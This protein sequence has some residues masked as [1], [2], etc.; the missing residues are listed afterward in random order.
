MTKSSET[1]HLAALTADW[2]S[3][4]RGALHQ[5]A[6]ELSS[7]Q[8]GCIITLARKATCLV[9]ILIRSGLL[10]ARVPVVSDRILDMNATWLSGMEVVVVDDVIISGSSLYKLQQR[11]RKLGGYPKLLALAVDTQWWNQELCR[12]KQPYLKLDHEQIIALSHRIVNLISTWPRPYNIDWPLFTAT[13]GR[14]SNEALISMS[15]WTYGSVTTH[16]QR[17]HDVSSLTFQPGDRVVGQL[18]ESIGANI[19]KFT[20]MKKVRVVT[21]QTARGLLARVCPIVI[22]DIVREQD[23]RSMFDICLENTSDDAK[24]ALMATISSDE[25]KLNFLQ[26]VVS[27][28]L[29]RF[30][31]ENFSALLADR[32]ARWHLE[33]RDIEYIFPPT[34]VSSVQHLALSYNAL[35][36]GYRPPGQSSPPRL[37][38]HIAK[39][40]LRPNVTNDKNLLQTQL[41]YP[42]I[43]MYKS[44]EVIARDILYELG[45]RAFSDHRYRQITDRL[46]SGITVEQLTSLGR[47]SIPNTPPDVI[48]TLVSQFLDFAVDAGIAVPVTTR[49][50]GNYVRAFRH[51][52]DV[53]FAEAEYA[54]CRIMLENFFQGFRR[55]NVER[56]TFEKVFVSMLRSGL[57]GNHL[58]PWQGVLGA[59]GAV[60]IRFRRHGA[61][62]TV[63]A[64][65]H[66]D[67]SQGQ[68]IST[69][70]RN[71]NVVGL[72]KRR[73]YVLGG[74][75][76]E[77]PITRAQRRWV[78]TFGLLMGELLNTGSSGSG[79]G[80]P[81]RPILRP[82]ELTM[83]ASCS[84]KA[85]V[86]KALAAEVH[87][88]RHRCP[89]L[90][91]LL[92]KPPYANKYGDYVSN[93]GPKSSF[94]EALDS[95]RE[96]LLFARQGKHRRIIS[97]V[98]KSL[99]DLYQRATWE[100]IADSLTDDD[101]VVDVGADSLVSRLGNWVLELRLIAVLGELWCRLERDAQR[102][103][104]SRTTP[105]MAAVEGALREFSQISCGQS[106]WE[107]L[108]SGTATHDDLLRRIQ[109]VDI[110]TLVEVRT[111]VLT[112]L[113]D[114]LIDEGC[115]RSAPDGNLRQ[116]WTYDCFVCAVPTISGPDMAG[117]LDEL[118]FVLKISMHDARDLMKDMRMRVPHGAVMPY[119][120]TS[121]SAVAAFGGSS[122]RFELA[123]LM[124]WRAMRSGMLPNGT[125]FSML[126]S[127]AK[128]CQVLWGFDSQE[129]YGTVFSG[130]LEQLKSLAAIQVGAMDVGIFSGIGTPFDIDAALSRL[131]ERIEDFHYAKRDV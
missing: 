11:I 27:A 130:Y 86:L 68:A 52:E 28:R 41:A 107:S 124:I 48:D 60:G 121:G 10:Q 69:I 105:T 9:D 87:L 129:L 17:R 46:D 65:D 29:G 53:T 111:E 40:A 37:P 98:A 96:K 45:P 42:F 49:H 66:F 57:Q 101:S 61:V 38:Q 74:Y 85:D 118:R 115:A 34:L 16:L 19:A 26:Y 25:A 18:E 24:S 43:R 94:G 36:D 83:L 116:F 125:R 8:S 114:D 39:Q 108:L 122:G 59:E 128:D 123:V 47:L 33:L 95:G 13:M 72:N 84:R 120:F 77:A 117:V 64:R 1:E 119:E 80:Q 113:A 81:R 71:L 89:K 73:N 50:N 3:A 76:P 131:A 99:P 88:T 103:N 70:L 112:S 126:I 127:D 75:I 82:D 7:V 23:L 63:S 67:S 54:L 20:Q 58:Q 102:G 97:R 91:S 32:T 93:F 15:G 100:E 51:G 90:S 21:A 4:E 79:A 35:L 44:R 31:M 14:E 30:W 78:S 6:A 12:P 22:F 56:T 5:L 110:P 62:A 92:R 104:M 2:S 55:D 106:E 109:S